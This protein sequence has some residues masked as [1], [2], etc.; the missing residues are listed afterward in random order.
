MMC[1]VQYSTC[2]YDVYSAGLLLLP[3][4]VGGP[5]EDGAVVQLVVRGVDQLGHTSSLGVSSLLQIFLL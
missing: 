2:W 1:T 5:A 3:Q 4:A